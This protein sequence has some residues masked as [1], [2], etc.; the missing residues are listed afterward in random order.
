MTLQAID[1]SDPIRIESVVIH[2]FG[3]PGVGKSTLA[4]TSGDK[5]VMFD[6]DG[7]AHRSVG[8]QR[9]LRVSSWADMEDGLNHEWVRECDTL[10]IDTVGRALEL[11]SEDIIRGDG[12][13]G[14][15][16]TGLNQRGFGVLKARFLPFFSLVRKLRKD[17]LLVSHAKLD[18]DRD[19]NKTA[20]PDIVGGSAGEVFKVSDVIGYLSVVGGRRT[21]DCNIT[22][23][24][25][26]KN[27]AGWRPLEVPNHQQGPRFLARQV[28]APLK[29]HLNTLSEEQAAVIAA[30]SHWQA[31][32]ESAEA[33][34]EALTALIPR[35]D[36][37][38]ND[39]VKSQAKTLL[40]RR[41]TTVLHF[42]FDKATKAFKAKPQP[43]PAPERQ[44]GEDDDD[45]DAGPDPILAPA[46]ANAAPEPVR[47]RQRKS[48]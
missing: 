39:A 6:F 7:A 47:G 23:G 18:K 5:V 19:G 2:V 20:Y 14:S 35:L 31:T 21:L 40:W 38:K 30:V 16:L 24:H 34:P 27:P 13:L 3:D 17:V 4:N 25:I 48:A 10:V 44:P 43:K 8:R 46:E 29:E 26:G 42:D 22:D 15:A 11:L 9:I 32:V 1:S 12:K 36:E 28:I 37:E 41:A 45:D 33:T